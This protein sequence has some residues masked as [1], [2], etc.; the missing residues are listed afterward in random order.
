MEEVFLHSKA[1]LTSKTLVDNYMDKNVK[2]DKINN[3]KVIEYKDFP[4]YYFFVINKKSNLFKTK[5]DEDNFISDI[6]FKRLQ[7]LIDND[8]I[9]KIIENK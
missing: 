6:L 9:S 5:F 3:L 8:E 4:I 1:L 7:T 2:S